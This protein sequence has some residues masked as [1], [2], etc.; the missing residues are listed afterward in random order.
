MATLQL[1]E[2]YT[3]RK[4]KGVL[5]VVPARKRKATVVVERKDMII[6]RTLR[7]YGCHSEELAVGRMVEGEFKVER[8]IWNVTKDSRLKVSRKYD[9][10]GAQA[11][12]HYKVDVPSDYP[13]LIALK[14]KVG[15][16]LTS[17]SWEYTPLYTP[18]A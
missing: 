13:L 4:V 8:G 12:V 7:P 16:G 2:G 6:E 3:V 15:H 1:P 18:A 14:R 10:R 9:G 11:D 5:K 17:T